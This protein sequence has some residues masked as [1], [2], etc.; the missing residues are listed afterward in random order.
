MATEYSAA[1]EDII[2]DH[3][4]GAWDSRAALYRH[5]I[6]VG[7]IVPGTMTTLA[8]TQMDELGLNFADIR[9]G[10]GSEAISAFLRDFRAGKQ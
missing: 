2:R 1:I 3:A 7:L 8:S 9:N 5:M 10:R 6:D 4:V